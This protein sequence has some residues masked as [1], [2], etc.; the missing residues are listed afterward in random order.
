MTQIKGVTIELLVRNYSLNE[1][2]EETYDGEW[3]KVDNVLY[4][5]P[6]SEEIA[7]ELDLT[8]RHIVYNLAIPKGDAND[9]EDTLVK[10]PDGQTYHTIGFALQGIE[11]L[12]PLS[13]NKKV[14]VERYG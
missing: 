6:S 2:G 14:K 9:W 13:W 10:L 3:I 8:G 12:I 5:E 7:S 4:G 11:G 1:I